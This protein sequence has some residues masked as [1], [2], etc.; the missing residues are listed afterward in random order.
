VVLYIK[1][2]KSPLH[3]NK[4]K[5]EQ[6]ENQ[7][8]SGIFKRG[9]DF[10]GSPGLRLHAFTEGV[11]SL[12]P[13]QGTNKIPYAAWCG[14]KKKRVKEREGY[15]ENICPLKLGTQVTIGSHGFLEH[16]LKSRDHHE[17]PEL[18]LMNWWMLS[19]GQLRELKTMRTQAQGL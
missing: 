15:R 8:S 6:I 3:L 4:C 11:M 19:D 5:G 16:R 18:K 1:A 9:R 13:G 2:W 14:Q 7:N 10:P 12:I 17:K